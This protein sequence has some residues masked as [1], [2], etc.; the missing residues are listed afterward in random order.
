MNE[1]SLIEITNLYRASI[2][3]LLLPEMPIKWRFVNPNVVFQFPATDAVI[4]ILN[5]YDADEITVNAASFGKVI[6]RTRGLML[7]AKA[8]AQRGNT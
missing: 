3:F 7:N 4:D 5:R 8:Q 2:L 6:A 1:S